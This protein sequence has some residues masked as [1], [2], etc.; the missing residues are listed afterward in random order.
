MSKE[1]HL[2]LL[3]HGFNHHYHSRCRLLIVWQHERTQ[4]GK[5]TANLSI[6]FPLRFPQL[7]WVRKWCHAWWRRGRRTLRWSSTCGRPSRSFATRN[8]SQIWTGSPSKFATYPGGLTFLSIRGG[9]AACFVHGNV[10]V[11]TV[12]CFEQLQLQRVS[13]DGNECGDDLRGE[14]NLARK[15]VIAWTCRT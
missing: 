13:D 12:W 8:R 7:W 5:E 1:T 4:T 3:F 14:N 2:L 11:W 9:N 6:F 15:H 10:T